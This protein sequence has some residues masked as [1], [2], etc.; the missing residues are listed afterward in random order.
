LLIPGIALLGISQVY[1]PLN[2]ALIGEAVSAG[3]RG[4]AYSLMMIVT[5]L[6]G[7]FVPILAGAVADRFGFAVVFPAAVL[8]E[9]IAF[10][11]IWKFLRENR[12]RSSAAG[13]ARAIL[14]FMKRAWIPP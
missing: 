8:F 13:G 10:V 9:A 1:Q 3:N 7:I 2:A 4:S 14:D 12:P 11:L 6:P 5:T